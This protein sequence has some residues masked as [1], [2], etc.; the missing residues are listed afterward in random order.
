MHGLCTIAKGII[1]KALPLDMQQLPEACTMIA[2]L[3]RQYIYYF[4]G[5][6]HVLKKSIS[7]HKLEKGTNKFLSLKKIEGFT[8]Q[9][10]KK[11]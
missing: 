11:L 5:K 6:S 8:D 1:P 2:E 10:S 7:L 3:A 9:N 4:F